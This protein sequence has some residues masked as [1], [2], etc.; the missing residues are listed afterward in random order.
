MGVRFDLRVTELTEVV[1]EPKC[2]L[3]PLWVCVGVVSW[4]CYV[5]ERVHCRGRVYA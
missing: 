5:A 4:G 2:G 3:E 1:V